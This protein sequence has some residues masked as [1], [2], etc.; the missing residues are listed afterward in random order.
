M[1]IE[2]A[3][4]TQE[5]QSETDESGENLGVMAGERNQCKNEPQGVQSPF[6]VGIESHHIGS[7]H[8]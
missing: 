4:A 1:V 6:P 2:G 5:T 3:I 8:T 7:G